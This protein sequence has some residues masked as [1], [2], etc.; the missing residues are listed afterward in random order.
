ML[1]ERCYEELS[2]LPPRDSVWISIEQAIE[3][4]LG[5]RM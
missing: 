4:Q 2:V 5:S 3:K 1:I